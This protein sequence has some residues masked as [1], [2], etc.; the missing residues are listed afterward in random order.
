MSPTPNYGN[1]QANMTIVLLIARLVSSA[2]FAVSG[3]AKL[4]D[5]KGTRRAITE[6]GLPRRFAIPGALLLPAF[7]LAISAALLWNQTSWWGALA[8][9]LLLAVFCVVIAI[10]LRLGRTPHC[11]CFGQIRAQ[12]VSR[13]TIVRNVV[14]AVPQVVVLTAGWSDAVTSTFAWVGRL[15]T[16]ETALACVCAAL[17]VGLG[18]ALVL[19]RRLSVRQRELAD[20]VHVMERLFDARDGATGGQ[21]NQT[22]PRGLPIGALAPDF[23][24]A[25]STSRELTLA[26]LL[27]R[28]KPIVAFFLSP[29]CG[30]CTEILPNITE[31]TTRL[32]DRLTVVA[33]TSAGEEE[34][35][36]FLKLHPR[37]KFVFTGATALAESYR[38]VW[39]PSAVVIS[40]EG[41]IASETAFGADS[42]RKLLERVATHS[43]EL[44]LLA[45]DEPLHRV[46]GNVVPEF[47]AIA[48]DGR[49]IASHELIGGAPTAM[50]FW[51]PTCP[52]CSAMAPDLELW[53]QDRPTRAPNL[54]LVRSESDQIPLECF[55]A[56]V[57]LD[58]DGSLSRKLGSAGTPSAVLVDGGAIASPVVVGGEGVRAL[59]GIPRAGLGIAE[60]TS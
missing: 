6:F 36:Q 2:V 43:T 11:N 12:P 60:V 16:A 51:S 53:S 47:R 7:E 25:S 56:H 9:L 13:K 58:V 30:P 45:A 8:A 41:R 22:P 44:P 26:K 29:A 19:L 15:R 35:A 38:S 55:G 34:N 33:F 28:E 39:T 3:V 20:S 50:L 42:I 5:Q 27:A 54:V 57:V 1:T 18:T 48:P 23:A 59:L 17:A 24:L 40:P 10:N 46:V 52:H 37:V 31:W 32:G 14:L 4:A 21:T 49:E